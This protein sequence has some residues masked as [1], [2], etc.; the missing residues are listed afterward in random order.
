VTADAELTREHR[1]LLEDRVELPRLYM[2]WH[3]P[4]IFGAG[5][6]ELDLF[7]DLLANGKTS[8]LYRTLVYERRMAVDVSA[9]QSSRELGG[10]FLLV[11]TAAPGHA[12]AD[13]TAVIDRELEDLLETGPT[14]SEM[15]RAEAQAEAH[16]LYRLQTVGGFGGKSD[17]LNAY[18]VW[19]RDPGFFQADLA[20]YR[21]AT[22]EG[23]QAAAR[24]HLRADRRV[25][26]S[27]V[28]RGARALA[29]PGS[30]PVTV[31]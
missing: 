24:R 25:L 30:E 7:G 28:P 2:A 8:R 6:A 4:A 27:V 29:L 17:Q 5:D 18:N 23:V 11:A 12:L 19:R 20:R 10:Y 26:L 9:F 14:G 1:L 3:S 31:A 21:N 15:E 22:R 16:F 13:V